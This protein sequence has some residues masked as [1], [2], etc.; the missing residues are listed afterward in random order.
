[1]GPDMIKR[2]SSVQNVKMTEIGTSA[3]LEIG[4]SELITPSSKAIAIQRERAIF[5]M[6]EIHFHNFP[7]FS[8]PI[9]QPIIEENIEIVFQ[10][11]QPQIVVEDIEIFSTTSSS[12]VHLGSSTL[13]QAD[14]R[15]KH[16]RHF[17]R[18]KKEA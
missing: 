14:S 16:I 5:S 17:L 7:I 6:N 12:I 10:H 15:I 4:D 8:I 3:V 9:I 13:L 1:M 2:V 18:D 11:D